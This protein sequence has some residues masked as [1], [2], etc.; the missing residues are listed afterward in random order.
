[1]NDDSLL[2]FPCDFPLK[3]MGRD[4]EAFRA[5]TTEIV[6]RHASA[7]EPAVRASRDARYVSMSFTIKAESREQLDALYRE[8]S[9]NEEILFVL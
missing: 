2:E 1:M 4:S 3:I 5:M 9:A 8:L 6:S 7:C